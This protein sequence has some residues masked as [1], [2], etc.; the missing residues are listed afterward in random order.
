MGLGWG[1]WKAVDGYHKRDPETLSKH[2]PKYVSNGRGEWRE[3]IMKDT[4]E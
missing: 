2:L 3:R 4:G 1:G